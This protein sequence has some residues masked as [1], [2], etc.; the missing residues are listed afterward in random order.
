MNHRI[1]PCTRDDED[2]V[3]EMILWS[4]NVEFGLSIPIAEQPDL[5][6]IARHYRKGAGNFWV[7]LDGSRVIGS[8]GL[9][10]L[11]QGLA[12][13]RKMFVRPEY[14]GSADGV[15]AALL[16]VLL[17]WGGEKGIGTIFLGTVDILRAAQRFYEKNG[18]VAVPREALPANF[19]SLGVDTKFYRYDL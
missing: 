18:F 16:G 6:D 5:R 7:A 8:I 14:R 17:T 12:A 1:R 4:Q 2:Q 11:G 9:I 3:I 10:D 19:L 15:A 13:L